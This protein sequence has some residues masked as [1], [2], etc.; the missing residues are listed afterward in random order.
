MAKQIVTQIDEK[1]LE[2]LESSALDT[3]AVIEKFEITNDAEMTQASELLSQANKQMDALTADKETLTKPLNA[4]LTNIRKRYKPTE[5]KLETAIRV[6]RK[7]IGA[8]QTKKE[9]DAKAE[10][11]RIVSRVGSGKGKL[12]METAA[13]QIAN[14][15]GAEKK[16][17]TES[18]SISF[19]DDYEITVVDIRQIPEQFL[20]VDEV[21]IKKV[22]KAGGTV[23]GVSGKKIKVPVN[24]R[25]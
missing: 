21:A 23:E 18:G 13:K 14:I 16:V 22:F 20:S 5:K 12:K 7:G 1:K 8:Y 11:A 19:R 15:D 6:L 4:V 17:E 25:A 3:V 10:E 2:K 24:R 9:D